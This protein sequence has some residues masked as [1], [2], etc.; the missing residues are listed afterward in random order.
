[1]SDFGSTDSPLEET[2]G[3]SDER[4]T[5]AFKQLANET[6]L[7]I[8]FTLWDA[9]EPFE[10]DN[11]LAF[12]TLRDRVGMR[13]KGQ[14]YYHLDKLVDRF[15]WQ[16]DEGYRLRNAGRKVV[17]AVIAGTGLT[18]ETLTPTKLDKPCPH[19]EASTMIV[20]QDEWL[21]QVCTECDGTMAGNDD[22]PAGT[23]TIWPFDQAGLAGRTAEEMFAAGVLLT[24]RQYALM[25]GGVCPECSGTVDA[26]LDVCADHLPSA[27]ALCPACDRRYAIQA[28]FVCTVCKN[29]M[30]G[31]PS[32]VLGVH[33]RVVAFYANRGVELGY[34]CDDLSGMLKYPKLIRRH[35]RA[36][37]VSS[38][39]VR[40]RV[41]FCRDDDELRLTLD[42]SFSVLAIDEETTAQ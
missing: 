13:D 28:R 27:D 8:L 20:Y 22:F 40:I 26:S 15:V 4:V 34:D 39:P 29:K 2:V 9:Y 7:A 37:L 17:R 38:D 24:M 42:D 14:F 11:A 35:D 30:W 19:C 5:Q 31:P 25:I 21:F 33:P 23:L 16:T 12:S 18:A 36:D 3:S 32:V 1:M 41:T 10:N 6:R